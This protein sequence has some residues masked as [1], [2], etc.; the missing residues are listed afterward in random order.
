M[1]LFQEI[2]KRSE[3]KC[4]SQ[5]MLMVTEKLWDAGIIPTKNLLKELM[6]IGE[7]TTRKALY[8]LKEKGYMHSEDAQYKG[9]QKRTYRVFGNE[10]GV[11]GN[12]QGVFKIEQGV[13]G[14]RVSRVII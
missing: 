9:V 13:V 12:E 10:Q 3:M 1:D 6:Q 4:T 2:K 14:K 5:L 8:E 11:F 7:S